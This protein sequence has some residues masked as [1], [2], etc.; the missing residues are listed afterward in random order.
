VSETT[1]VPVFI[2]EDIILP[3][4]YKSP[5]IPTP[6]ATVNAPVVVD[7]ALVVSVIVA[8]VVTIGLLVTSHALPLQGYVLFPT[9]H[10]VPGLGFG[11]KFNAMLFYSL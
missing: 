1:V 9:V 2:D 5:R 4:T 6:P 3:P 11:G 7:T 8:E 10:L